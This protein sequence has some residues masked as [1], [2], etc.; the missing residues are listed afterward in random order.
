[1]TTPLTREAVE[2]MLDE[3]GNPDCITCEYAAALL[4][5]WE[6]RDALR[7]EFDAVV[8]ML[9]EMHGAEYSRAEA[10]EEDITTYQEIVS[11]MTQEAEAAEA[12][13]SERDAEIARLRDGVE[14]ISW[15][16]PEVID[17]K[18]QLEFAVAAAKT[19]LN[20]EPKP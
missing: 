18:G 7:K 5:A 3:C 11:T 14:V 19:L 2:A 20:K 15:I 4:A 9:S 16:D 1:M 12:K 10:A 6:E 17:V 13:L 8:A